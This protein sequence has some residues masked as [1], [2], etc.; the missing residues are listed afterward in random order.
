MGGDAD[1]MGDITGA[2][3][4]AFYKEIPDK[5]A[6]HCLDLLPDDIF[7]IIAEFKKVI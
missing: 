5:I 7:N 1:T 3:A 4:G 2:I 6:G